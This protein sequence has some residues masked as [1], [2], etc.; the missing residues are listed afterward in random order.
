M[1]LYDKAVEFKKDC[2]TLVQLSSSKEPATTDLPGQ[3]K[4]FLAANEK[5]FSKKAE[6]VKAKMK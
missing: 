2:V 4:L 5:V 3:L 6:N 1:P